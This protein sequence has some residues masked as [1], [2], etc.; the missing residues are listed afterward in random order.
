ME[1]TA[2]KVKELRDKTGAGMMDCK[3]AL[4][5]TEGDFE[6]AVDLLRQKGIAVAAKRESR[7]ASE[8]IIVSHISCCGKTGALLE[9]NCETDFVA[10]TDEF[11]AL[12][13][14][15]AALVAANDFADAESLGAA[16]LGS[17]TVNDAVTEVMGK[18]GEKINIGR[19]VKYAVGEGNSAMGI[20]SAYIHTGGKIGVMV[21][22]NCESEAA[23]GN[24]DFQTL[25]K[26]IAMQ[27]AWSNPGF[28]SRDQI[29]ADILERERKIYREWAVNEGKPE[30]AIP[31]I[32][33]GKME[34]FYAE[35]CLMD[36][37]FIRDADK[38][39]AQLINEMSEKIG[40]K[41]SIGRYV[42][43]RVGE[44]EQ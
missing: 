25:A 16:A 42:R 3:K 37:P 31:K 19:F 9:L 33:E 32:V 14:Q 5:D 13:A 27:V 2:E 22:M 28:I 39:I 4:Q 8:G 11:Q 23:I 10:R 29:T 20:I 30:A 44:S 43:L 12:A 21:E 26:D 6:K 18:L 15:I 24:E 36:L 7:I 1:I 35:N 38:S 40:E 34:S 17:G 41:I